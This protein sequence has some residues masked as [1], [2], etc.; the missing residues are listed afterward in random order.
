MRVRSVVGVVPLAVYLVVHLGVQAFALGGIYEYNRVLDVWGDSP[1]WWAFEILGLYLPLAFHAVSGAVLVAQGSSRLRGGWAEVAGRRLQ[2]LSAG[3]LMLFLGYHLWQFRWRAWVGTLDRV[4]Y[5]A[6]LCASLSSTFW[7]GVP[8]VASVYLA[9]LAAAAFHVAYGLYSAT[10][11]GAT[12]ADAR[13]TALGRWCALL[14]VGLFAFGALLVVE[15]A[16]GGG[17]VG[18]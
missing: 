9:G 8:L 4:D 5:F 16:T 17:L 12:M 15:L 2:Q 6:E 7:Q 3:V 18:R 13:R 10:S 11:R 14:G 1:V